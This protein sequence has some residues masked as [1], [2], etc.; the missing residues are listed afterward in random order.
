[1]NII[2]GNQVIPQWRVLKQSKIISESDD[3][4]CNYT[5]IGRA[6]GFP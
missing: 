6:R 1:M 3:L 2:A 4:A 5:W